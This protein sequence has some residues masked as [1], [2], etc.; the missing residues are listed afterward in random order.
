MTDS[1]FHV[2]IWRLLIFR[3]NLYKAGISIKRTLLWSNLY[4]PHCGFLKDTWGGREGRWCSKTNKGKQEGRGEQNS[5]IVSERTF[6]VSP[7]ITSELLVAVEFKFSSSKIR[8]TILCIYTFITTV[9]LQNL[10]FS[11]SEIG[12]IGSRVTNRFCEVQQITVNKWEWL[13]V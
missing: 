3:W 4:R 11:L 7:N 5:G 8:E 10:I 1:G 2:Y 12:E 9:L 6:W 13:L